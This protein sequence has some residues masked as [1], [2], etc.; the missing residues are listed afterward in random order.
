MCTYCRNKQIS[1][2]V[3]LVYMIFRN[4]TEEDEMETCLYVWFS[5]FFF[6]NCILNADLTISVPKSASIHLC[7]HIID[8][9]CVCMY[10]C[11]YTGEHVGIHVPG[12]SG[13][14][15]TKYD[16]NVELHTKSLLKQSHCVFNN[17]E[18]NLNKV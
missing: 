9:V 7:T 10:T 12:C 14:A 16:W 8:S 2:W 6:K 15:E 3:T 4:Y 11:V 18:I 1:T 5:D 13:N 17:I